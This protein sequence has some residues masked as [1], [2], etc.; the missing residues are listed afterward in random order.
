MSEIGRDF[1]L[2]EGI[3]GLLATVIGATTISISDTGACQYNKAKEVLTKIGQNEQLYKYLPAITYPDRVTVP[4]I[5]TYQELN[6]PTFGDLSIVRKI[7][8][9]MVRHGLL[10]S[11]QRNGETQYLYIGGIP[12]GFSMISRLFVSQGGAIFNVK[13]YRSILK[14]IDINPRFGILP[15]VKRGEYYTN[16]PINQGGNGIEADIVGIFNYMASTL[17]ATISGT[18]Y[19]PAVTLK[20]DGGY[21]IDGELRSKLNGSTGE[22]DFADTPAI[23]ITI[24]ND[25]I[26]PSMPDSTNFNPKLQT[27]Y[28]S[29]NNQEFTKAIEGAPIYISYTGSGSCVDLQLRGFVGELNPVVGEFNS[30]IPG[31]NKNI[32]LSP[33]LAFGY[34]IQPPQSWNYNDLVDWALAN[35]MNLPRSIF[36]KWMDLALF[37]SRVIEQLIA[38]GYEN[39]VNHVIDHFD[40]SP[41]VI[42]KGV[43]SVV[44]GIINNVSSGINSV[45]NFLKSL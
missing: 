45:I 16:P 42:E 9:I 36:D 15:V 2:T 30:Y 6:T 3:A 40:P 17:S 23:H 33:G 22:S 12:E 43:D 21:Y 38:R 11:T 4:Y 27:L 41:E 10:V 31:L 18:Y 5:Q 13:A 29:L 8:S 14:G 35:G 19:S 34:V 32:V 7:Q 37:E 39:L 25:L 20:S 1:G 28:S 44:N 26:S 24:T